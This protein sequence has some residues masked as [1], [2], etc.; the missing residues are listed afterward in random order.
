MYQ[1]I[2]FE[3]FPALFNQSLDPKHTCPSRATDSQIKFLDWDSPV[4]LCCFFPI[5]IPKHG[6][7]KTQEFLQKDPRNSL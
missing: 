1:A 7:L 4:D 3:S 5:G 2:G 6:V